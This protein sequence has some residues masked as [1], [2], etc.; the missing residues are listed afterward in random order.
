[1]IIGVDISRISEEGGDDY[2]QFIAELLR[3]CLRQQGENLFVVLSERPLPPFLQ[4]LPIQT[5]LKKPWSNTPLIRK[6]W[7]DIKL[8]KVLKKHKATVFLTFSGFCS[9]R[10]KVP[11]CLV[12]PSL[13]IFHNKNILQ[14]FAK[15]SPQKRLKKAQT[16]ITFSASVKQQL[17]E[18]Y[19]INESK[20][21]VLPLAANDDFKPLSW[22]EKTVI[23]ERYTQGREYFIV[24]SYIELKEQLVDLLKAFSFFKKRQQSGMKL[25]FAGNIG[26]GKKIMEELLSTYKYRNDVLFVNEE[27]EKII[28]A[29]YAMIYTSSL[30]SYCLPVWQAINCEVPVVAVQEPMI[31]ECTQANALFF[32]KGSVNELAEQMMYIYKDENERN[33]LIQNGR[34][35]R[36]NN[37]IEKSAEELW[38][39]LA[40]AVDK[41]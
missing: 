27:K 6:Y 36:Q 3:Q 28:A 14:F 25:M 23:K 4:T 22:E 30:R 35:L 18:R 2:S 24:T 17:V 38:H 39:M 40:N 1:M 8:P 29:A 16:I 5:Q 26:M 7:Y 11:Q 32:T 37:T 41:Q 10:T 31:E 13:E 9:L 34:E 12:V 15:S 20:I 19:K 33:R 21:S